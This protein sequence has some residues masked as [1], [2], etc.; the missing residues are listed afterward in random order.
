[1]LLEYDMH[2]FVSAENTAYYQWQFELMIESFIE[3]G[4]QNRLFIAVAETDDPGYAPALNLFKHENKFSHTNVGVQRGYKKL[5]QLY[6][7]LYA[8]EN[9]LIPETYTVLE[10]HIC[11]AAPYSN[12][13]EE[14]R[15]RACVFAPDPSFTFDTAESNAGEFWKIMPESKEYYQRNWVPLGSVMTFKQIPTDFVRRTIYLAETIILRQL[16]EKKPIWEHSVK[17]AWALNLSDVV[18][19]VYIFGTY[20]ITSTMI[21]AGNTT[22][23]DYEHGMP[24]VFNKSMFTYPPP[25][26]LAFGDPIE[27]LSTLI[28][29]ANSHYLSK[30]AANILE[31]RTNAN[32]AS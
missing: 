6:A 2:F 26:R 31:K 9:N 27:T 1:M 23:I 10:P 25:E 15:P 14:D 13:I 20:G 19:Q 11:L 16:L 24:P 5:N 3:N 8:L 17:L 4:Q 12:P 32:P 21:D 22:F 30:L 28:Q 7:L 18:D 29:T